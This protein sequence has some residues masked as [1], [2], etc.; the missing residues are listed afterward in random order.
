MK[1][2]KSSDDAAGRLFQGILGVDV[3]LRGL[4][5]MKSIVSGNIEKSEEDGVLRRA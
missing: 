2:S 3:L 5:N 4:V 1:P